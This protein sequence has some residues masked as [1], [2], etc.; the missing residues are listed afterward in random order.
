MDEPVISDFYTPYY[1]RAITG[2]LLVL[3][4]NWHMISACIRGNLANPAGTYVMTLFS[5][6]LLAVYYYFFSKSWKRITVTPTEIIVDDVVFKK[7]I[8]IPYTAITHINAYRTGGNTNG[9]LFSQ[10]FVIEFDGDQS[11]SINEA[12]YD[13]YNHLTT[14]I[15]IHK[16]GPGHGRERYL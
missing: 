7:Q 16:Y 5:M 1:T 9:R 13:N 14:T 2:G 6:M 3:W 12:W 15:Y 10:D 4:L 11:V 8:K